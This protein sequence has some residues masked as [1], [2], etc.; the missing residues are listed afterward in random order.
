LIPLVAL[1]LSH[2]NADLFGIVFFLVGF[3]F[4]GRRVGFEPYLLDIIPAEE[5]PIYSGMRETLNVLVVLLP[6]LRGS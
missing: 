2:L 1:G 3:V 6:F 5:R 4:S